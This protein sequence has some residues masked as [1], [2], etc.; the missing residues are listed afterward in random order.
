MIFK[1]SNDLEFIC[2]PYKILW[3]TQGWSSWV[4][5]EKHACLARDVRIGEAMKA[6]EEDL[7]QQGVENA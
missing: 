3:S 2:G 5:R 4:I 6:C 1:A 7:Q